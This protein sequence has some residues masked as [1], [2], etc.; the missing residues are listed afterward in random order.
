MGEFAAILVAKKKG[1]KNLVVVDVKCNF[2]HTELKKKREYKK[3]EY[4]WVL[5]HLLGWYYDLTLHGCQTNS[6][7]KRKDSV[8]PG[9]SENKSS[10]RSTQKKTNL[11]GN[12]WNWPASMRFKKPLMSDSFNQHHGR[13]RKSATFAKW[14]DWTNESHWHLDEVI[15]DHAK[16]KLSMLNKFIS[17]L[18]IQFPGSKRLHFKMPQSFFNRK[19]IKHWQLTHFQTQLAHK[20]TFQK[21]SNDPTCWFLGFKIW[22]FNS[23][24]SLSQ[25]LHRLSLWNREK[26]ASWGKVHQKVSQGYNRPAAQLLNDRFHGLLHI[27]SSFWCFCVCV[28]VLVFNVAWNLTWIH[29][30]ANVQITIY[31]ASVHRR[32]LGRR[33]ELA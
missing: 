21:N 23:S 8:K 17:L 22:I 29:V 28:C 10:I 16:Q 3:K 30:S 18:F 2:A 5:R 25:L 14:C 4:S 12:P 32:L 9:E 24:A 13:S 6:A 15:H 20:S 27:V 19:T 11:D 7:A 31:R 26:V 33:S 1:N